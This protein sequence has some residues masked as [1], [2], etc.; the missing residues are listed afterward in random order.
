[1]VLYFD[2][3]PFD[4]IIL[5][6]SKVNL[7]DLR[8]LYLCISDDSKS[9]LDS[10]QLWGLK[11]GEIIIPNANIFTLSGLFDGEEHVFESYFTKY[12]HM[13]L[14]AFTSRD[15]ILSGLG[16]IW[17]YYEGITDIEIIYSY[18][19]RHGIDIDPIRKH[20]IKFF[21]DITQGKFMLI[22]G[23][24]NNFL[25]EPSGIHVDSNFTEGFLF[26]LLYHNFQV[27]IHQYIDLTYPYRFLRPGESIKI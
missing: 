27:R 22:P 9:V 25:L 1:M 15:Y 8:F 6:F 19:S 4:I 26:I 7:D 16:I 24:G 23:D 18:I 12:K 10:S 17:L 21:D 14:C 3:I 13:L 5:I 20:Y 2:I 11:F